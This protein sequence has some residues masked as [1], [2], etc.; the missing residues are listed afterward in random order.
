MDN[1]STKLSELPVVNAISN[2]TPF[3][4]VANGVSMAV[5]AATLAAYIRDL[6]NGYSL[7]DL[8]YRKCERWNKT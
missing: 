5:N 3:Y 8:A 6:I 2:A 1:R 4:V 7:F